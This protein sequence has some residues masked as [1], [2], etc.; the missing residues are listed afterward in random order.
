MTIFIFIIILAVLILI[1]EFGHFIVA[2]MVGI[3]VEEFAIGFPPRLLSKK[4]KGT[5]YSIN[6]IPLGGYVKLLGENGE[7]TSH[8]A[9]VNKPVIPRLVVIVAGVTM[10]IILAVVIFTIGY[11]IGMA[12]LSIDAQSLGGDQSTTVFIAGTLADSPAQKAGLESGDSIF[13][14]D[15][16]VMGSITDIQAFTK[17][18]QGE[19]VDLMIVRDGAKT[20]KTITLATGDAPLGIQLVESINVKL[21]FIKALSAG[22][23]ETWLG[24]TTIV[25]FV[26]NLVKN[27]FVSGS[28]AQE[29]SG[30]VGIYTLTAQATKLGF[31]YLLSLVALL[32]INLAVLNIMPFPALDGGRALFIALEGIFGRKIVREQV[33][34]VIHTVGFILLIILILAI[35][36]RDILRLQ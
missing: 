33:E 19:T 17:K 27:I 1:H 35:T 25:V 32:S 6:L 12:P 11:M 20:D 15:M 5:T 7:S 14:L 26:I 36:A 30:P 2:R 18:H 34:S 29:V 10:N 4:I 28:V 8:K 3:E 23:R 16:E 21:S 31:T 13:S 24:I 22:L 9:F